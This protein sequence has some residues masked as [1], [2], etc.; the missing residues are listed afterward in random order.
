MLTW[1]PCMHSHQHPNL[2]ASVCAA[3]ELSQR[4]VSDLCLCSALLIRKRT[5]NS[6]GSQEDLNQSAFCLLSPMHSLPLP[7]QGP[8]SPS[9]MTC[10]SPSSCPLRW[11]RKEPERGRVG[12][13]PESGSKKE[14][15]RERGWWEG[16]RGEQAAPAKERQN[17]ECPQPDSNWCRR[18]SKLGPAPS[19]RM[20]AR[21][22]EVTGWWL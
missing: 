15:G 10:S 12:S 22:H 19:S 18:M 16:E 14:G 9:F 20:V 21:H 7:L 8:S 6:H 4:A 1:K 11:G 13:L 17:K 2:L 5:A 3:G